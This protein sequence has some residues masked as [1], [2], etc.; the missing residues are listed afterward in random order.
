L[1]QSRF[2]DLLNTYPGPSAC[3]RGF[4]VFFS[5]RSSAADTLHCRTSAVRRNRGIEPTRRKAL[6]AMGFGRCEEK[7]DLAARSRFRSGEET[8]VALGQGARG[9][10]YFRLKQNTIPSPVLT[11]GRR[12]LASG[13]SN[14]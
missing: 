8:T 14:R 2:R 7:A 11:A 1:A 12:A 4:S 6:P 13:A 10:S 9:Q 5:A 3:I